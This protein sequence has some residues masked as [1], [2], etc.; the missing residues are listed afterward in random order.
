MKF[1]IARAAL[2]KA[3]DHTTRIVERRNTI[4]ILG[5]IRLA[6][7]GERLE[8]SATD[9]DLAATASAEARVTVEGM[10]TV[11][12]ATLHDIVRKLPDS[13]EI[14]IEDIEDGK[15][16]AV[17][18]GR[19]RFQLGAITALDWPSLI[20]DTDSN[21]A[22]FPVPA[23]LLG[24]VLSQVSF[25][26]STEETRYYLN[27]VHV[28]LS[29]DSILFVATDGHR[30]ARRHI[31]K[32]EGL[33]TLPPIIL[34]R[35]TV[36]EITRLVKD[37]GDSEITIHVSARMI[38]LHIG[39]TV[40]TSKLIDGTFPDYQRVIPTRN[41]KTAIVDVKEFSASVDRVGT[42]SSDRGRAIKLA[43]EAAKCTCSVVNADIG[44]ARDEVTVEYDAG[45]IEIGFNS[46]Y[47]S[48][49]MAVLGGDTAKIC[50]A[51]PA[52]PALITANK[53]DAPFLIVLMPMRV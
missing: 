22:H 18:A 52:S 1:T 16:V 43:W 38:T 15:R 36:V 39:G 7:T 24:E 9:L 32:P 6:A 25:A 12:A 46:R 45:P 49:V 27:G 33:A 14:T 19:S 42:L 44:E 53:E 13:C 23:K 30:L 11:P 48:E 5:N 35:K 47:L 8:L 28:H 34:P 21:V 37:A 20:P 41:G 40:L 2:L 3:L 31:I 4:P 26:I 10:T 51:D 50:L 17:R 29:G